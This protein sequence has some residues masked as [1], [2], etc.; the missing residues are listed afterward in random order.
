MPDFAKFTDLYRKSMQSADVTM[1]RILPGAYLYAET[2]VATLVAV[3]WRLTLVALAVAFL[4]AS[5][6][7]W[8]ALAI[9]NNFISIDPFLEKRD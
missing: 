9:W 4:V 3:P 1:M 5:T 6:P 2:S 7:I 8:I